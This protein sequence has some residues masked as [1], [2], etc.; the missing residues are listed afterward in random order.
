[1]LPGW[2]EGPSSQSTQT[3][4]VDV[5]GGFLCARAVLGPGVAKMSISAAECGVQLERHKQQIT[6]M[7]SA[8]GR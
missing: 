4:A 2:E 7:S 8:E 6:A 1:M 3:H 5:L